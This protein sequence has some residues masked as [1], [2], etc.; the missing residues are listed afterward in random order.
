M[1]NLGVAALASARRRTGYHPGERQWPA[2]TKGRTLAQ[3]GRELMGFTSQG[4][5]EPQVTHMFQG[6]LS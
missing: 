2:D 6:Q 1:A 4:Y 3:L 5:S